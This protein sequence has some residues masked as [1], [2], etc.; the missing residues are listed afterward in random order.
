VDF[1]I[2]DDDSVTAG[3]AEVILPASSAEV[4]EYRNGNEKENVPRKMPGGVQHERVILKRGLIGDLSLYEWWTQ[5]EN[6][7]LSAYR[8]VTITLQS[9]DRTA[10]VFTWTLR[11]AWP[12]A[13]RFSPLHAG[14]EEIVMEIIELAY[15]RLFIE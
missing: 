15:E 10:A 12:A 8:D 7:D 2:G 1:G 4:V 3:F 11:N 6:G 9:E 5:V 13:Y 14:G